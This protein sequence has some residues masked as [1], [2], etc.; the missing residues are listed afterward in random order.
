MGMAVGCRNYHGTFVPGRLLDNFCMGTMSFR[1]SPRCK[2]QLG[3][4]GF[5]AS[6]TWKSC[7]SKIMAPEF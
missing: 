7:T 1:F 5:G 6:R 4:L 3:K 2:G